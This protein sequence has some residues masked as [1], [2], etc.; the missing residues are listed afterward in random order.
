MGLTLWGVMTS[1]AN[2]GL[3]FPAKLHSFVLFLKAVF[4]MKKLKL[5]AFICNTVL[6]GIIYQFSLAAIAAKVNHARKSNSLL[7]FFLHFIE[8]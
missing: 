5:K 7:V 6:T 2:Y 3:P 8:S 4:Q 1:K